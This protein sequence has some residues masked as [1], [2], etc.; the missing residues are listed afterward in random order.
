[1]R[2]LL[3]WRRRRLLLLV[4]L[5]QEA[6]LIEGDQLRDKYP[7][8]RVF[9]FNCQ[10]WARYLVRDITGRDVCLRGITD[11]LRI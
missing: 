6:E 7:L 1:M 11:I 2:A 3:T 4:I 8:Y 10:N 9:T 5:E